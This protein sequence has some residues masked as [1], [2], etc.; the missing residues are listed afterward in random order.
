MFK[1]TIV[2]ISGQAQHGKDTVAAQLIAKGKKD[3]LKVVRVAYADYLKFIARTFLGWD[4]QKDEAGRTILQHLGTEKVRARY[5]NFWVET[6]EQLVRVV[7]DDYDFIVI[8][9][10][11][12]PNEINHWLDCNY[13]VKTLHV[14]R[15]NFDNGLTAEQRNHPSEI[16]LNGFEF[17][18]RLLN[19]SLPELSNYIDEVYNQILL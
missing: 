7:F 2:T 13:R 8:P 3:G 18:F 14:T 9:D 11:R 6:V 19:E 12:F 4:G 17:D 15:P 1:P 16:A 10:C 5:P